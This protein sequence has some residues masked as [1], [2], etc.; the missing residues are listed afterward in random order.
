MVVVQ[1]RFL[2]GGGLIGICLIRSKLRCE[3]GRW[4]SR[5]E[6]HLVKI[7][8]EPPPFHTLMRANLYR[9]KVLTFS[10]HEEHM[11]M[12]Y[13]YVCLKLAALEADRSSSRS[14]IT[15]LALVS[16]SREK[17]V[18]DSGS[19]PGRVLNLRNFGSTSPG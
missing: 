2:Q 18:V 10:V 5:F 6:L 15:N 19:Q 7:A 4:T 9:F 17:L 13:R 14:D 1:R 8:S 16:F 11:G 3:V 12:L